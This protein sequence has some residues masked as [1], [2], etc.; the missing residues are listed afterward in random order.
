MASCDGRRRRVRGRHFRDLLRQQCDVSAAAAGTSDR[1][2]DGAAAGTRSQ[3]PAAAAGRRS[4]ARIGRH[5]GSTEP[6]RFCNSN[7]RGHIP[8]GSARASATEPLRSPGRSPAIWNVTPAA[9]RDEEFFATT[10]PRRYRSRQSFLMLSSSRRSALALLFLMAPTVVPLSAFAQGPTD[11]ATKAARARFSEGVE[12]FD[13]HDYENARTAF[14]QAYALRKH[15]AVLINLA[16][17]SLR[18]GHALEADHY[19]V[20]YLHESSGLTAAQR[21]EAETGLA[22]ARTKLGRIQVSAPG[23][24]DVAVDGASAGTAPLTDSVDVEPGTHSVKVASD[25][26]SIAVTAGQVVDVRFGASGAP[27]A[28][29]VPVPVT[30]EV[31]PPPEG[32]TPPAP[33]QPAPPAATGPGPFSPPASMAPVWVGVAVSAAGFATAIVFG[34]FKG[35]AQDNYNSLVSEIQTSAKSQ[36]IMNTNGLCAKN[37]PKNFQAACQE[38]SS[39]G[40]NVSSDATVANV[41]IAMGVVGAGFAVGWYLL[42]PK[43]QDKHDGAARLSVSPLVGLGLTGL[44]LGGSF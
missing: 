5:H 23:G 34:V 24:S 4:A 13:K 38:L 29:P 33:T 7:G 32:T 42:A 16:Q 41:G 17:S 19:F 28:L 15:P 25:V 8:P 14:L 3:Y 12:F 44:Q 2:P 26:R 36:G 37:T 11:A 18:A 10:A 35:T 6:S 9:A 39:D 1:L 21:T 20:Q 43:R 31:S 22:E 27:G 40:S 30:P